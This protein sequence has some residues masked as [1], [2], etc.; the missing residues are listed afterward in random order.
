MSLPCTRLVLKG[1]CYKLSNGHRRR[2][3][4][5]LLKLLPL[6]FLSG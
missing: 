6:T 3:T 4:H 2:K 5:V 1:I